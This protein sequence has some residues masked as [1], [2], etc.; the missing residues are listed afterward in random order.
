[1]YEGMIIIGVYALGMCILL[2]IIASVVKDK[3][4]PYP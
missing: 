4:K 1:M 2:P 3:P